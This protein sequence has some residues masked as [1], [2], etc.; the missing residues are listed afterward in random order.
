M[1]QERIMAKW[2]RRRVLKGILGGSAITVALPLLDCFLND[3]GEALASGAP[4]PV[5]FGTWFWPC[6]INA[7]RWYPDKVGA[8]YEFKA[9]TAPLAP[10]RKKA[11]FEN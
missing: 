5:R 3:H 2:S 9:E 10:Y 8:D 1:D 6:G 11:I 4:M 7:S